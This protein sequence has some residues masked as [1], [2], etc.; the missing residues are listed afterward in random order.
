E[1]FTG[2]GR[3]GEMF[4]ATRAHLAAAGLPAYEVSNHARP[5]YGARHNLTYWRYQP[6]AG[7]GPGAHGRLPCADSA[8]G[9]GRLATRRKRY[10]QAWMAAATAVPGAAAEGHFLDQRTR[11]EEAL[12]MGLRLV[13]GVDLAALA[14]L[15]GAPLDAWI[16]PARRADLIAEGLL[17]ETGG[18][19]RAVGHGA[20]ML[21]A[22]LAYLLA[23]P[24]AG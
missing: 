12:M 4:A 15:T 13:E 20:L 14:R 9:E 3:T 22:V 7:L 8:G 19:L 24:P 10:P 2:F 6:Y 11:L 1:I 18:R 17:S 16:A 5:G 23:A 21:D